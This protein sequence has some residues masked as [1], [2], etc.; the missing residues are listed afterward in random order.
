M[1]KRKHW[2]LS[3]LVATVAGLALV[4]CGGDDGGDDSAGTGG[5]GQAAS[6]QVLKWG[7]G[8]EFN[9]DPGLATDTTSSKILS[10][11]FD[12]LVKLDKDL[13][14]QP[15]AAESWEV[16]GPNVTY[17]LRTGMTWTNGDP[18]TAKDYEFAWKRALSPDLASDYA[19]QLYGIKGAAEYNECEKNCDALRDKVAIKA[20]DDQTL[21]VTLTSEQPWFIEQSAHHVFLPVNQ[22]AVE[23]SPEQWTRP[24]NIV[25]NGPFKVES[26]QPSASITLVKNEEWRDAANVALTRV[27]G[28]I[29]V[30]GTTAVQSFEAG[31]V[32]VL[33]E[34]LPSE[35]IAR[36][37]DTPEYELYQGLSTSYYGFN[38]K[39]VTD[40]N[41]RR[42]MSLAINRR[43]I[44]DNIT[45]ANEIPAKGFTPD[46]MPGFEDIVGEGSPWTPEEGDMEKAKAEMEKAKNP[47]K[48]VTIFTN[49]S[50]PNED[51][52]VAIQGMWKELGIDSKIRVMEWQQYLEMLGPPPPNSVDV[53]RLGWVGDFVDDINFL[54]LWTCESGNNN[55]NFC[56]KEYDALVAKAK[57]TPDNAERFEI[58]AQLEGMLTGENGA[59]PFIP[60]WSGTYNNL[61]RETV[62]ETFEINLLDQVDLTTVEITE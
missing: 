29:I 49:E 58:Y 25:T 52:A 60:L 19:Y 1:Q 20:T 55:T 11:I 9:L 23:A 41:Q 13:K 14:A 6:E 45:Q 21:E 48:S 50:P 34:Q 28:R 36:L 39:Q 10:N 30:D 37:K 56:D 47:V 57:Q 33:D 31:E 2:L 53:F 32:D 54:E 38:I 26:A 17:R 12:P 62:K 4:G 42:A 43:Q 15:A 40:L 27:E 7:L 46:G 8:A 61:E 3:A 18:V 59:L 5:D 24:Q 44:I 22:K 51:V 35:E 16:Q